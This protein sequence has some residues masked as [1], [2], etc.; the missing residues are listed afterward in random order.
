LESYREHEAV[1][2]A[3]HASDK[4]RARECLWLNIQ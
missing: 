3:L 4:E 1:V 2:D